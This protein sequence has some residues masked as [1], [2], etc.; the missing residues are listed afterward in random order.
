M[1]LRKPVPL[2]KVTLHGPHHAADTYSTW[3]MVTASSAVTCADALAPTAVRTS[4]MLFQSV[5]APVPDVTPATPASELQTIAPPARRW[6]ELVRS[7]AIGAMNR[8]LGSAGTMKC[9]F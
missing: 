3:L 7:I 9:Q 5:D 6:L 1:P 2:P 8:G 4:K